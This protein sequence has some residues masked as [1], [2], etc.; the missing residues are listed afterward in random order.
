MKWLSEL[1]SHLKKT[2]EFWVDKAY[3]RYH[4]VTD[5]E[6]GAIIR[7]KQLLQDRKAEIV[8]SIVNGRLTG[9]QEF[10][11]EKKVN[12]ISHLKWLIK[13]KNYFYVEEHL[14]ERQAIFENGKL[15]MDRIKIKETPGND[16][17]SNSPKLVSRRAKGFKYNRLKAVKY[18]DQWWD[19]FN[20]E[21]QGFDV[22]CTN[23][24][25]Q[26]I[27]AGG[28]PMKGK[29]NKSSG[30]WYEGKSWSYS[31]T[32]ANAFRLYLNH[33][34]NHLGAVAVEKP[35]QLVPGDVI[36]YDFQGDG[37]WD[38]TTFVTEKDAY[39][40]PLVNAHTTNSRHRYWSYEDSTAWTAN[41]KYK[42]YHFED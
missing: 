3:D 35:E 41:I 21:F 39:G 29:Y 30:W 36:C 23:Y 15:I 28:A 25:S 34:N 7:K 14:E 12:Y 38:H 11:D 20:P 4:V 24:V 22:D 32:V 33:V 13:Q 2:G 1:K 5:A 17:D 9:I 42:F 10:K 19:S 26:C 27:F 6:R 16:G 40:M 31:W 18:A 37:K 8:K